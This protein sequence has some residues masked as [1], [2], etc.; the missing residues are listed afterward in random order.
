MLIT[1]WKLGTA[2]S[3]KPFLNLKPFYMKASP[4]WDIKFHKSF[5]QFLFTIQKIIVYSFWITWS[6]RAPLHKMEIPEQYIA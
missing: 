2:L 4:D 1:A 3:A 6:L 5:Y